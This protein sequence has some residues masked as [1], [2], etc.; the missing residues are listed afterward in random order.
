MGDT[1]FANQS[2]NINTILEWFMSALKHCLKDKD[3]Y[4]LSHTRD[5]LGASRDSLTVDHGVALL[6]IFFF[7]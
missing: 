3:A 7:F 4:G 2:L 6:Q 1:Y 5:A